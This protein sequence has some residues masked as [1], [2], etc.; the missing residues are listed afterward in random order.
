M[1]RYIVKDV[2]INMTGVHEDT[3]G[4]RCGETGSHE[5]ALRGRD[6]RGILD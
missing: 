2:D 3:P 5:I 6:M 1:Y 4:R